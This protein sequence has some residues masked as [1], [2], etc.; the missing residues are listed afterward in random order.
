MKEWTIVTVWTINHNHHHSAWFS[1][2]VTDSDLDV[3]GF[4]GKSKI[5]DTIII[6]NMLFLLWGKQCF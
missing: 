3:V 2:K 4:F 1:G 6:F 5:Q